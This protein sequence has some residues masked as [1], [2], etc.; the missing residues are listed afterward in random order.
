MWPTYSKARIGVQWLGYTHSIHASE[1]Y[2]SRIRDIMFLRGE[3]LPLFYFLEDDMTVTRS[4]QDAG[5]YIRNYH[6]LI[7]VEYHRVGYFYHAQNNKWSKAKKIDYLGFLKCGRGFAIEVKERKT[8]DR[9]P[10][11]LFDKDDC[12]GVDQNGHLTCVHNSGAVATIWLQ[13]VNGPRRGKDRAVLLIWNEWLAL[14]E[15]PPMRTF[16]NGRAPEPYESISLDEIIERYPHAEMVYHKGQWWSRFEADSGFKPRK[17]FTGRPL[18]ER[19][20][21]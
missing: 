11:S 19:K 5:K 13:E 10:F 2:R 1:L 14:K 8:T 12:D 20:A 7:E 16:K 15:D 6:T 4:E 3:T 18:P 9:F 17:L 21:A